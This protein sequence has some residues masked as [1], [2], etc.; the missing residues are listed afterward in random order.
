MTYQETL[1]YLSG[2]N[3]LGIRLGLDPLRALLARMNDPQ[4]AA[5][6]VLIAGTNGKGSVAAMT[7]SILTAAGLRTGLYTSPDLLDLRERV[8]VD[9]RMI[10]RRELALCAGFVRGHIRDRKSVV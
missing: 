7:A 9:G 6:C 8:R 1:A 4:N 2:L 5:P 3:P 10:G